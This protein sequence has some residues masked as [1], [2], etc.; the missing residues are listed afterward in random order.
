MGLFDKLF[1]TR[2]QREI[3]RIQ[4]MV[5]KVLGLEGEYK[6][7][8]DD[9]IEAGTDQIVV[10]QDEQAKHTHVHQE[11]AITQGSGHIAHLVPVLQKVPV[12]LTGTHSQRS[13]HQQAKENDAEDIDEYD[14]EELEDYEI[15]DFDE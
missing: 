3:K 7:L 2:S 4:P 10:T 14:I 11:H 1:G 8:N 5:D 12:I 6:N 13:D 15:E 9:A